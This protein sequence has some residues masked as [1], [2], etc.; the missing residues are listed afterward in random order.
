M[1]AIHVITKQ[2]CV[3]NVWGR[4]GERGGYVR[5]KNIKIFTENR[6]EYVFR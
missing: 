6:W 4:N 1:A 5:E 2:F 3:F